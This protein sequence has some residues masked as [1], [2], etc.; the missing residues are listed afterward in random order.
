MTILAA[1][2]LQLVATLHRRADGWGRS[3]AVYLLVESN[4]FPIAG[5][6]A[7]WPQVVSRYNDWV[8]FDIDA[9]EAGGAVAHPVRAQIIRLPG[10]RWLLV[11]TDILNRSRL[12]SR[13]RTAMFWGV[14][15]SVLLATL[16]GLSYSRR[17]RRRIK[18]VAADLAN[19]SWPAT[20]PSDCRSSP[21]MTSSTPSPPP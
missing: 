11:G 5:N 4:G 20:C 9:S 16:F 10:N 1:A 17:I 21:P 3:G 19:P 7:R 12:A 13:L 6:L 14:G 18:A 8:E 15:A 2:C